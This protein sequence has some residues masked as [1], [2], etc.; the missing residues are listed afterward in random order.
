MNERVLETDRFEQFREYLNLLARMHV[1]RKYLRK[2]DPS[3]VVNTTLF[4][5]EQRRSD[6]VESND[7]GV[8]AWLR[9][10]LAF[11]LADALRAL[12]RGKRDIDRECSLEQSLNN[13]GTRIARCLEAIQS[14][15]SQRAARHERSLQLA[16][17]LARLPELQRDVVE[18]HHL[19]GH[20]ISEV[21]R[22]L[23]RTN[24]SVAGLL[25][26]GLKQLRGLLSNDTP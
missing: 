20:T 23:N 11:D 17:A 10:R 26:R 4:A 2:V 5:A 25:R 12:H 8:A 14:S 13:S 15:P 22:I 1:G 18:L 24:A 9:Q 3:A 19:Q 21:A 16:G 7:E 6:F